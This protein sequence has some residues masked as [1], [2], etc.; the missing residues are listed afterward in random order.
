MNKD[1]LCSTGNST[2]YFVITYKRE[3]NLEKHVCVC[4]YVCVCVCLVDGVVSDSAMLW[5]V[6]CPAALSMGFSRQEYQKGLPFP[7][8]RDLPN[9]GIDPE[10]PALQVDSLSTELSENPTDRGAWW[11]TVHRVAKGSYMAYQLNNNNT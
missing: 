1:L 11:A 7:P 3:K 10:S 8:P 6:T 4:V 9:P 5:T 2:Q